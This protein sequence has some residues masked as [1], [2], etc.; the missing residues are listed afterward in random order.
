M[1]YTI[2]QMMADHGVTQT[3]VDLIK[4]RMFKETRL[5]ELKEARKV[6]GL[7]QKQLAHMLGVSQNR[8]SRLESGGIDKVEVRT[9]RR[10]LEAIGGDLWIDALMPDGSTLRLL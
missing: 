5:Y 1:S 10:Y 2:E 8:I 7:T 3:E 6:G 4:A 9:L